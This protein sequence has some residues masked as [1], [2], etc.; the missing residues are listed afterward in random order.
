MHAGVSRDRNRPLA[1]GLLSFSLTCG[2]AL[3]QIPR[4][5]PIEVDQAA[6]A[7][8]GAGE[9]LTYRFESP[10]GE[11]YLIEV[12]QKDLDVSVTLESPDG[13]RELYDSP[14][15]QDERELAV[16]E[17]ALPGPYRITVQSQLHVDSTDE[18][19]V[20]VLSLDMN[21]SQSASE[22]AALRLMRGA[23]L[24]YHRGRAGDGDQIPEPYEEA[25]NAYEL[26]AE[27]WGYLG[28][29]RDQAQA[30][31]SAATITYLRVWDWH[32]AS[33]LAAAAA[34]SYGISELPALRANALLLE[35]MALTEAIYETDDKDALLERISAILEESYAIHAS[36][37]NS[38]QLARIRYFGGLS[39]LNA[40][41]HEHAKEF[42]D[43]AA[44]LFATV[45]DWAG[46]RNVLLDRAVIDIDLGNNAEAIDALEDLVELNAARNQDQSPDQVNFAATVLDQL[47]S[48]Y[49]VAGNIDAALGAFSRAREM[50]RQ[51]GDLH[52]EA[53]SLRGIANVYLEAGDLRLGRD[54]L[55]QAGV[56]ATNSNNGRILAVVQTT[57]GHLAYSEGDY[58]SAETFYSKA[59]EGA[60]LEGA[61][62]AYRQVLLAR[63][64]VALGRYDAARGLAVQA[65]QTAEKAGSL[66]TEADALMELG[67][68]D[69][70]LGDPTQSIGALEQA[71]DHYEQIDA[72]TG[73]ADAAHMVSL[74]LAQ[75]SVTEAEPAHRVGKLDDALARSAESLLHVEG[76]LR[77]VVAPELRAY[78]AATH[79]GYYETHINLLMQRSG[80]S[81][82]AK[83]QFIADALATSERARARMTMDLLNEASVDLQQRVD[84]Q[85]AA[86]MRRLLDELAEIAEEREAILDRSGIDE[87]T[88]TKFSDLSNRAALVKNRLD[89]LQTELRRESTYYAALT[90]PTT[91]SLAG[92]QGLVDDDSVLLQYFLGDERS[93]VW[94]VSN[95]SVQA[96]E[97]AGRATIGQATERVLSSLRTLD[98]LP[99]ARAEEKEALMSLS[100]LILQPLVELIGEKRLVVVA[101]GALTYLPFQVLPLLR[102]GTVNR[103]LE[104][105]EVVA[106]PSM[107]VLAAL[108]SREHTEPPTK[109][110]AAFADPVFEKTDPRLGGIADAG[111]PRDSGDAPDASFLTRSSLSGHLSRLPYTLQEATAI[112]E[113][114]PDEAMSEADPLVAVG[115]EASLE[116]VLGHAL[117]DYRFLHFAT[118]GKIDAE[119]P[120][121]SALVLSRFNE[122]GEAQNGYLR[123]NDIF[124]M[125]LNADL[126]VLSACETGLGTDILGEGL[127]GL[128]QG[129]LY[130]GARSLLVSLWDVPDRATAELMTLF[131]GQMLRHGLT[132]AAALRS[133]QQSMSSDRRWSDPYYWG[134]FTL[135]G[136]W[137]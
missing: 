42:Y 9:S 86:E 25:A 123:L 34:A 111:E 43:Q 10:G 103:L 39:N 27:Q 41:R 32:G 31:Y 63:A 70:G 58:E 50:H 77:N 53:E 127:V 35:A 40:G 62:R 55:T 94:V 59:L 118:H 92:I 22:I 66:R 67:K 104:D 130:A 101:D 91:V 38:D 79:R 100:G 26:A 18:F 117:G 46:E 95:D 136:D 132:P 23:E 109:W 72:T 54:F 8:L 84:P 119:I 116:N 107:S 5:V 102:D 80:N 126:V 73:L 122:H 128:T 113:L 114:V 64:N 98:Y 68:A 52:G 81:V 135:S 78:Y 83:D 129:F 65:L 14:L 36:L 99:A 133:A 87:T 2:P 90:A 44:K 47:G 71:I 3:G 49:M 82:E 137:Q 17:H 7:S 37:G 57:L 12:E 131:Y 134:A 60:P 124:N 74:A 105:R 20:R 76:L 51:T 4:E 15:R 48:A 110:L 24:H 28:R 69:L 125:E 6:G 96:I 115:F 61:L 88:R 16:V 11:S 1:C 45:D 56:A 21:S 106:L 97:L 19:T 108:R 121:L 13:T 75:L 112:A 89:V 29:T 30:L 120:A 85:T 93:F 33:R